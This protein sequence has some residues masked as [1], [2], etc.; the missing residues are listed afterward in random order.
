MHVSSVIFKL[1]TPFMH[2]ITH[3]F[4]VNTAH[5]TMDLSCTIPF[6]Q[7][8]DNTPQFIFGGRINRGGHVHVTAA[9]HKLATCIQ[10]QML[11][12]RKM[13]DQLLHTPQ[14]WHLSWLRS[15]MK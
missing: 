11:I 5:S 10:W 12:A 8:N 6:L 3:V 15:E 14:T 1:S 13:R 7:E 9:Q 2:T 4:S